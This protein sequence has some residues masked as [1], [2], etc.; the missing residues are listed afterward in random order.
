[1]ARCSM[2]CCV[3]QWS[4]QW[5]AANF[6]PPARHLQNCLTD[7]TKLET[8]HYPGRLTHVQFISLP[9]TAIYYG[10]P[11][12]IIFLSCSLFF[13]LLFLIPRHLARKNPIP[14]IP[15]GS[16]PEMVEEQEP[17]RNQVTWSTWKNSR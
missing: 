2:I 8:Q 15:R 12:D 5:E 9:M 14:L 6:E 3:S 1:M 10:R 17:R 7:M 16:L 11:A 13:L 4:K